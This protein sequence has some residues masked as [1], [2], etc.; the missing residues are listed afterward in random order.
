MPHHHTK[1]TVEASL[2]CNRCN[3]ETP[4][5]IADGRQQFCLTCYSKPME[6]KAAP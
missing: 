1:S 6:A 3:K 4:W 2:W 5:R